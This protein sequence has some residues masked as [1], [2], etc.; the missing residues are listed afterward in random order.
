MPLARP[1][2]YASI[3]LLAGCQL[4][5]EQP[6]QPSVKTVRLQGELSLQ[7]GQWLFRPC[8]EQRRFIIED[9]ARTGLSED[10]SELAAS[11]ST[12]LYAD[13]RGHLQASA[14]PGTDGR[15]E[16]TQRYRVQ[17]QGAGCEDPN[18]KRLTLHADGADWSLNVGGQGLVLD[19]P[20]QPSL[21]LPYMEEQL[22]DGRFNLTSEANNQRLELWVAPQRCASDSRGSVQHLRA[23]LRLNGQV[24]NGC[25]YYG[26]ARRE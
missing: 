13:L 3:A 22:P 23:E 10:A 15:F 12:A 19:R 24:Q 7:D 9:G 8:Q 25:A 18:F 1:L 17:A 5:T 16:L 2:L 26:G 4:F 21:A 20:G 14:E 6:Q 11:A